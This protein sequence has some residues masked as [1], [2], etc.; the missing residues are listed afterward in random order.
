VN[1]DHVFPVERVRIVKRRVVACEQ[2]LNEAGAIAK[3]GEGDPA[4][5]TAPVDPTR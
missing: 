4:Q 1:G 5:I 3:V 2:E